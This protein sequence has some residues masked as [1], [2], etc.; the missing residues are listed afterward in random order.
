MV[1]PEKFV[2]EDI[3]GNLIT[4]ASQ[5]SIA[6]SSY[7]K[8]KD[9]NV[10]VFYDR[11]ASHCHPTLSC[12]T[13]PKGLITIYLPDEDN[14][15]KRSNLAGLKIFVSGT[16]QSRLLPKKELSFVKRQFHLS[17]TLQ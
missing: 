5:P 2:D 4:F 9:T 14:T 12:G 1:F 8:A 16:Y 15:F 7:H 13:S 10:P 6:H 17:Q 11:Q 3:H